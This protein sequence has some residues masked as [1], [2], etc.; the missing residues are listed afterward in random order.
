METALAEVLGND[1][2]ALPPGERPLALRAEWVLRV[3]GGR[4]RGR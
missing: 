3:S 2:A 1:V 4:C